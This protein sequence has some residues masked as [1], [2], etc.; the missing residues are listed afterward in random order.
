MDRAVIGVN[1]PASNLDV[2]LIGELP[3]IREHAASRAVSMN[4]GAHR[5]TRRYIMT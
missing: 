5:W 2:C 1:P 4:S 3:V